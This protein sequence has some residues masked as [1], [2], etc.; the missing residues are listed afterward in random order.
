MS[1]GSR[2]REA[3]HGFGGRFGEETSTERRP[4]DPDEAEIGRRA[5][6]IREEKMAHKRAG[7]PAGHREPRPGENP[8]YR[9]GT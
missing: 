9:G 5:A 4:E 3:G 6:A 2:G 1:S 7:R 8:K